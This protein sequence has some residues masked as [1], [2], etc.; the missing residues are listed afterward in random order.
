[1]FDIDIRLFSSAI[2]IRIVLRF[3]TNFSNTMVMPFVVVFF[4]EQV[5]VKSASW[6]IVCIGIS[7]IL[8]YLIGGEM[9]DQYGRKKIILIGELLLGVGFIIVKI[10]NMPIGSKPFLS[11]L[12]FIIIYFFSSVASPAYSAFIIDETTDENRKAVYTV[13]LCN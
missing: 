13:L 5:G 9:S 4:V 2:K 10:S 8:G 6:M 7:S 3:L 1:M 11:F 12:G